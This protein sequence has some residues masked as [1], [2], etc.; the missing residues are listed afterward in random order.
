MNTWPRLE[1]YLALFGFQGICESASN[2]IVAEENSA[3]VKFIAALSL[4]WPLALLYYIVHNI[5]K[6][7]VREKRAHLVKDKIRTGNWARWVDKPPPGRAPGG[8][9]RRSAVS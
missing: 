3:I 1:V 5:K 8:R 7:V 9:A 4:L 2:A 6:N